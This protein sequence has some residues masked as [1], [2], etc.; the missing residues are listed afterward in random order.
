[1]QTDG[2]LRSD[3]KSD[4]TALNNYL[5]FSLKHNTIPAAQLFEM[6][7]DLPS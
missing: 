2:R 3:L 6:V 7:K 5:D 4:K 1:M